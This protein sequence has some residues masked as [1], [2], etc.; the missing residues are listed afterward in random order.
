MQGDALMLL[1]GRFIVSL[2]FA[3]TATMLFGCEKSDPIIATSDVSNTGEISSVEQLL[4]ATTP[5]PVDSAEMAGLV[6]MREEEK[7]ARDVYDALFARWQVPVF[8]SIRTSEQRHSDA[9][10][11]LLK[12][13]QIADPVGPNAPGVFTDPTLQQLYTSL[14]AQGSASVNAA[15]QVGALIEDLDIADL[16]RHTA[17]SDNT[18]IR[19]VYASLERGS[20][21]H[22]RA[23]A[24]QLSAIG[25]SYTPQYISQEE[26]LS[27]IA[28]SVERGRPW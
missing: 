6:T 3:V 18:D 11:A 1:P 8:S 2:A 26:Y 21:N 17:E 23:F 4:A 28:T 15:L 27:I 19:R 12:R 16:Q 24:G 22:L 5:E 10:L 20:R 13:Y 14:V 7:L 9:V 25:V